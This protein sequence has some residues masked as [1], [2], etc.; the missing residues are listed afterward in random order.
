MGNEL[1]G[2]SEERF[3]L[4]I[5]H[6]HSDVWLLRK[7]LNISVSGCICRYILLTKLR[8]SDAIWQWSA[9]EKQIILLASGL[10]KPFATLIFWKEEFLRK[11]SKF[12]LALTICMKLWRFRK[13]HLFFLVML[14][15]LLIAAANIWV[16]KSNRRSFAYNIT[17]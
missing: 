10:E 9:E 1:R 15:F 4:R 11:L 8:N 13:A 2:H 17:G 12:A 5:K 7:A 6:F 16:V 3:G 14:T